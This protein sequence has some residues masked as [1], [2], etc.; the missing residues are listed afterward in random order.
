MQLN[1]ISEEVGNCWYDVGLRLGISAANLEKI[2]VEKTGN[3]E[4]ARAIL[5]GWK[6]NEGRT[7]T[8]G[9]LAD[10]LEKEERKDIVK[11]LLGELKNK[12]I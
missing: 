7:A 4:K 5:I 6:W 12:V 2:D 11:K 10:V 9:K 3:R 1:D 8:V